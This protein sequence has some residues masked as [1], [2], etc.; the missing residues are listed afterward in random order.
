MGP[1]NNFLKSNI[2]YILHIGLVKQLFFMSQE[3]LFF[4]PALIGNMAKFIA[5]LKYINV[6]RYLV[7]GNI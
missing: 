7:S 4:Q 3:N 5:I 1:L 6:E 2:N